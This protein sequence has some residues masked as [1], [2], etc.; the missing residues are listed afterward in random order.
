VDA[1]VQSA[2]NDVARFLQAEGATVSWDARPDIDFAT[3]SR[4]ATL[5][6]RGATSGRMPAADYEAYQRERSAL[7]PADD[8]YPARFAHGIAATHRDWLQANARRYAMQKAWERF[9]TEWNVLIC[10]P[11]STVAF[12]HDHSQPR[13]ERLVPVNGRLLPS[14]SQVFWAGLAGI[15]YLPATVAPAGRSRDGLPIGVQIIGRQYGDLTCIAL[16]RLLEEGFRRFEPPP[17][18]P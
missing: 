18:Q 14:I 5:L 8:S 1:Q 15:A 13:H 11:A 2:V 9:F 3:V 7:D 17:L 16:A 4:D 10:P 12:R 6:I